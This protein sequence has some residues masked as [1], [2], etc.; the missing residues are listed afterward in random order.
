MTGAATTVLTVLVR[1]SI[2]IIGLLAY[3]FYLNWKLTL[4]AL[5]IGP[6]IAL[7]VRLI[8]KRLRRM[9]REVL[10]SLGDV[11]HVHSAP[12]EADVLAYTA[13]KQA[14]GER[15]AADLQYQAKLR[16]AEGDAQSAIKRAEGER[17]LKMVD[18]LED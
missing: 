11:V 18:E 5:V 16:L 17:A 4:I 8:S 2:A 14:E 3:L 7:T 12:T 13:V 10:R 9:S 1:D 6:P 15:K